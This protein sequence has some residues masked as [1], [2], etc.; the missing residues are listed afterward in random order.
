MKR[1]WRGAMVALVAA[2]GLAG[3]ANAQRGGGFGFGRMGGGGANILAM[4]E[5]QSELKLSD[6][7]KTKVTD[8]VTKLRQARQ[9]GGQDF[10]SLSPE[11]R[12]KMQADR[13]AE[14][15]KQVGGILNADQQKRYHQL[16]LQRQGL[17]AV[18]D[19]PVA[20][21]LKLTDEQRTKIEAA[22]T[23][24]MTEMRS[25]FQGGA[26]GDRTAMREKMM[27]MQK[28]MDEKIAAI[29]TDDQKKQWKEMLGASFTFPAPT[30]RVGA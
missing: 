4:P 20:D 26:G 6:E 27:A 18:L 28:Q 14:E 30:A 21:E 16:T 2:V 22:R 15:E 17:S 11:E 23:E 24:Q 12:A 3:A 29:L 10:R 25:L 13:R 19:K 1:G 9:G 8:M 7:Q 5:V